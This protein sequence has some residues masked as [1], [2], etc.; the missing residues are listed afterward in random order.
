MQ[1]H[2]RREKFEQLDVRIILISFGPEENARA[3]QIETGVFF[4]LVLDPDRLVYRA[5]ETERSFFLTWNL[6]AVWGYIELMRAGSKWRGIQGD[7]IQLGGDFI[8]DPKGHIR[9]AFYSKNPMDRPAVDNI[10]GEIE[11]LSDG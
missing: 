9:A 4:P 3:W 5:Y 11:A 10:L 2:R 8:I 6:R 7:S 1:L